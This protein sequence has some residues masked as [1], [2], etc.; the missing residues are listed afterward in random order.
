MPVMFNT[1]VLSFHPKQ[2]KEWG[3]LCRELFGLGLG[4]GDYGHMT[5]EH[6]PV[7][8]HRLKSMA[9]Y[10]NQGFEAAHK[11]HRQLYAPLHKSWFNGI[12]VIKWVDLEVC[13]TN[14]EHVEYGLK[15]LRAEFLNRK[16]LRPFPSTP[17]IF[18]QYLCDFITHTFVKYWLLS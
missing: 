5:I 11:V 1:W 16:S 6:S 17:V 2:C 13:K 12:W 4:T 15:S 8:M 7:L 18:L 3:F 9:R 10:S 14:L